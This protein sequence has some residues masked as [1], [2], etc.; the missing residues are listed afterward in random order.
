MKQNKRIFLLVLMGVLIISGIGI[1]S[2]KWSVKE[3]KDQE[4]VSEEEIEAQ[5]EEAEH[6][7][8]GKYPEQVTYTLGKIADSNHANLPLNET[9]ENNAYTRYLKELLN[10]QNDDV[11][12]LEDSGSYHEAVQMAIEDNQLPDI[13]VVKGRENL[14]KLVHQNLV[15]D[16]TT[17]YEECTT[18]R[19]K[20]MYASYGDS[21]LDS[22]TFDGKL[23][24]FPDTVVDNGASLMWIRKDW[25]D[26]LGL[27]EPKTLEE[28]MEI[29]R[30]FVLRDMA[31]NNET[32]GV[33]CSTD[34]VSESS[35]TYGVDA[36]FDQY[37]AAP[38]QWILDEQDNV[39]YGSV[40]DETKQALIYLNQ[41]YQEGILDTE[42]I[43]R[44]QENID[45]L[46]EEGKCGAI[47]GYW[48]APNNPLS[49][50]Y[51]KDRTAKWQPYLLTGDVG[52]KIQKFE[53]Y[54]DRLYVVVRKGYEHPEIVGKYVSALFDYGRFTDE[55]GAREVNDYFMLNVDPTARPL[56]INVDYRDAIYRTQQNI[57]AVLEGEQDIMSLTGLEKAYYETCKSYLN[58]NI[59]T[60]N[61]W[62]AYASRIQA[63]KLLSDAGMDESS[64]PLSMGEMDIEIPT[65]LL[66]LEK[67]T[68]LQII[69]GEKQPE[70]FDTFVKQWY[71]GG[72]EVVTQQAQ[73]SFIDFSERKS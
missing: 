55:E 41:L 70:Y 31:G 54:D 59:T 25:M 43:L 36:V 38:R 22:A 52:Q 66:E 57:Q 73:K 13:L 21:L 45:K 19:I 42:F 15:E 64:I 9:Y 12:E 35:S 51:S 23:Y 58:G 72:G 50:S 28:G 5:W 20:S 71:E 18:E 34:L 27:Q 24:A 6:T 16:L 62:A 7:P 53:S 17:V 11:F 29:V 65:E 2:C 26:Q 61:A 8:Y 14:K 67:N 46:L 3:T 63:T 48:W 56:N 69:M 49:I 40:T 10:I 33:V 44:T 47:F 68:F 4:E 39:V 60:S 30:Q 1:F 32:V 37:Q